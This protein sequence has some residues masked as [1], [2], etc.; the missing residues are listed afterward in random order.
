MTIPATSIFA[1]SKAF[2]NVIAT[3]VGLRGYASSA[4]AQ[5]QT[6]SVD[7][8]WA[9]A[10]IDALLSFNNT[11]TTYSGTA[12]LNTYAPTQLSGYAGTFT[13]DIATTQASLVAC[14]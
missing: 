11:L 7:T 13:T 12:G 14:I 4:L 10:F 5:L 2:E 6:T 8:N 1:L 3:L 9:Y